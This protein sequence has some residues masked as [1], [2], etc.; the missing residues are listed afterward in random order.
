MKPL[1]KED[2]NPCMKCGSVQCSFCSEDVKSAVEMLK[3]KL[4]E[5]NWET[6]FEI[7]GIPH[8]II[9]LAEWDLFVEKIKQHIKECFPVFQE[10]LE[11]EEK[12]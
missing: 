9:K 8:A 3:K 4:P 6:D 10:Q 1:T 12:K 11:K 2:A 7:S 5:P